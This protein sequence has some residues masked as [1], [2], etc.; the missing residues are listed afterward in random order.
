MSHALSLRAH[1]GLRRSL[2]LIF[3][4]LLSGLSACGPSVRWHFDPRSAESQVRREPALRMVYF[5]NWYSVECTRF[6]DDVLRDAAVVEA[7]RGV[8]CVMLSYDF[9]RPLAEE[10]GVTAAPGAALVDTGGRAVSSITGGVSRD[11]F[12]RWLESALQI[13]RAAL[14][15]P[16]ATPVAPPPPP[17]RVP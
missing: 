5:R 17:D 16:A 15:P 10:W 3:A 8:V 13:G 7:L 11:E 1:R 14:E 12:L 4:L 6:E 9:D 2:P